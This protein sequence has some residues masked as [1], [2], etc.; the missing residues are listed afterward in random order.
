MRDGAEG[1]LYGFA[2]DER[3][4]LKIGYR[5]TKYTNPTTQRDGRE[6]SAPIT[7]W[8]E[9]E[10]LTQ[11]PRHAMKVIRGFVDDFLPELADEGIEVATTRMCWYTD[12]FDN[13]LV[14]DHV[15]G[16]KGLMVATGGSGHAFKYL[17]VIGNWVVDII[18]GIGMERPQVKAWK[19]RELGEQKPV[20]VLME[21]KQGARALGNVPL[22]S[23]ADLKGAATVRL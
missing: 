20:N 18:E 23:D 16:R 14:I 12:S 22:A 9:G 8:S 7:R 2:R 6:R 19:W 5:G 4:Y 3:G 17:P 21:G 11:I 1:G 10:K 15:P 13:H